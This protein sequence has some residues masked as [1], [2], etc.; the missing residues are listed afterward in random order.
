[1]TEVRKGLIA[2]RYATERRFRIYGATALALTALFIVFLLADIVIKGL[3]AFTEHRVKLDVTVAADKVDAAKPA[4][5]DYEAIVREALRARFPTVSGRADRRKLNGLLSQ[6]AA[7]DLRQMVVA[8]PA[9]IGKTFPFAA[10]LSDDADL[11]FKG[12]QTGVTLAKGA[13]GL[14]IAESGEAY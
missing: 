3:P 5:G 7:D 8:D 2:K 11:F 14:Q 4:A 9:L 10:L 1:M 6:G 12:R 13:A